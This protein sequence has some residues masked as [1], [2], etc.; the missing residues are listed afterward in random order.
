M[1]IEKHVL[2]GAD[3]VVMLYFPMTFYYKL[4]MNEGENE[5][6]NTHEA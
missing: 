6:D 3:I 1:Y 2:T 4:R 5:I